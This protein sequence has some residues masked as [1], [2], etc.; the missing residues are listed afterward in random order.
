MSKI[1]A[2]LLFSWSGPTTASGAASPFPL[3]AAATSSCS[4]ETACWPPAATPP[5]RSAHPPWH[6]PTG[7]GKGDQC[8]GF[9]AETLGDVFTQTCKIHLMNKKQKKDELQD[10][11]TEF[12]SG[13]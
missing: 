3:T 1:E 5:T 9:Q 11:P 8:N 7:A 6:G 2:N 4:P 13:N 12:Y 10:G